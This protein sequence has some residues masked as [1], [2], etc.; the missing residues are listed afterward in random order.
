MFEGGAQL[1]LGSILR[2]NLVPSRDPPCIGSD[3]ED[4]VLTRIKQN[5]VRGFRAHS[6]QRQQLLSQWNGGLR[7]HFGQRATVILV[8][9]LHEGFQPASFLPKVS[10]GANQLFQT[11][12]IFCSEQ[13]GRIWCRSAT[14]VPK[15]H[16]LKSQCAQLNSAVCP[17]SPQPLAR[18]DVCACRYRYHSYFCSYSN[19]VTICVTG[20]CGPYFLP[21][22]HISVPGGAGSDLSFQ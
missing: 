8:E 3:D 16:G 4:W 18:L 5:G 7:E 22:S 13:V 14:S 2:C 10:R 17:Q 1:F 20:D 21:R 11:A 15:V 6:I 9:K 12:T 19:K